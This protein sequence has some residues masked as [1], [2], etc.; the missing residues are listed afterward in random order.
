M[1]ESD[2][3]T[4]DVSGDGSNNDGVA[5][6]P[7]RDLP[8]HLFGLLGLVWAVAF[9]RWFR[10]DQGGWRRVEPW[11]STIVNADC[12]QVLGIVDGRVT[13]VL[14]DDSAADCLLADQ[15]SD[16]GRQT[17]PRH[18]HRNLRDRRDRVALEIDRLLPSREP[19]EIG[20]GHGASACYPPPGRWSI[21]LSRITA[22]AALKRTFVFLSENFSTT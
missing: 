16:L 14:D 8:T 6:T 9:F 15:E 2:R 10:D 7:V 5:L 3:R 22:A 1:A 21:A 12:G 4:V 20:E 19:L 11:M 17:N 13:R 18:L